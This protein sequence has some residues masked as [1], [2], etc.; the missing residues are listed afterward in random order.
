M[1]TESSKIKVPEKV[2][3]NP[4][5]DGESARYLGE[6]SNNLY[7]VARSASAPEQDV[8]LVQYEASEQDVKSACS[9]AA[10]TPGGVPLWFSSSRFGEM[11]WY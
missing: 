11:F 2:I 1:E 9:S 10:H 4:P 5:I 7:F 3:N 6:L 8:C